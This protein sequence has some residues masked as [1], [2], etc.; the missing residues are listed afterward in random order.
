MRDVRGNAE[1]PLED[2][3]VVDP[4]AVV[5]QEQQVHE[6]AVPLQMWG[7]PVVVALLVAQQNHSHAGHRAGLD[8]SLDVLQPARGVQNLLLLAPIQNQNQAVHV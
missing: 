7:D 2:V 6:A 5:H 8:Q 3:L 1:R 4:R